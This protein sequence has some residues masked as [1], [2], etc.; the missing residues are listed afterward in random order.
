MTKGR[1]FEA[2]P[3]KKRARRLGKYETGYEQA[4]KRETL[5]KRVKGWCVVEC[6]PERS[7]SSSAEMHAYNPRRVR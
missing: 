3:P 5:K 6:L 7:V 1:N 4:K 2:S